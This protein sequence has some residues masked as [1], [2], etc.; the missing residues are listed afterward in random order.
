MLDAFRNGVSIHAPTRG[1]TGAA[2][3]IWKKSKVSIHAPTRGATSASPGRGSCCCFNP[4]S[5]AGSDLEAL[6]VQAGV[7]QFQSTL[8]RGE[9][10]EQLLIEPSRFLVS[11]HAPTRGATLCRWPLLLRYIVSIHAPTRGAT[12]TGIQLDALSKFQSTLP[13]G[14]RPGPPA[15]L[16]ALRCFNPRSHAGSD[17]FGEDDGRP[18]VI[19]DAADQ[20]AFQSTLPR[21]ERHKTTKEVKQAAMFQSTLPRGE[22]Q[23][24][25]QLPTFEGVEL[26]VLRTLFYLF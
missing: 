18:D 8:P 21:G 11:I 4:R 7:G 1:A 20:I 6:S 2:C 9:R 24:L 22:R 15:L 17:I 5:H 14:E 3:P 23:Y 26:W 16:L 25:F 10:H 13:R 12:T 19:L